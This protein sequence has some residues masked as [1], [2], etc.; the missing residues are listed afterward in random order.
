MVVHK[1]TL[2]FINNT[3]TPP[4]RRKRGRE[5]ERGDGREI[6]DQRDREDGRGEAVPGEEDA[7]AGARE[8]R[9]RR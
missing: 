3:E 7:E 6:S 1:V 2:K 9:R 4:M 5:V 8:E